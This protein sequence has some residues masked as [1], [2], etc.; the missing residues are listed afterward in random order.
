MWLRRFFSFHSMRASASA[1]L[2]APPKLW[3]VLATSTGASFGRLPRNSVNVLP[4]TVSF[5]AIKIASPAC[6]PA[7]ICPLPGV[8]QSTFSNTLKSST[9][10]PFFETILVPATA[11]TYMSRPVVASCPLA[12]YIALSVT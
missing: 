7:L 1:G 10:H 4:V 8:D 6:V 12:T 9:N 3:P 2:N 5:I 11:T